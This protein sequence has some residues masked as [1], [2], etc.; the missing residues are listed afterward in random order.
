MIV[1]M[2]THMHMMVYTFVVLAHLR[3]RWS[4]CGREGFGFLS[5]SRRACE[6]GFSV[7][8]KVKRLFFTTPVVEFFSK[9]SWTETEANGGH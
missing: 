7:F 8:V 6:A 5:S 9:S 3:R 1:K 4:L 2:L